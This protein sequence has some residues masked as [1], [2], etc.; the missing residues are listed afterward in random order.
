[1]RDLAALTEQIRVVRDAEK[2]FMSLWRIEQ[3]LVGPDV[4][5]RLADD[6]A[7]VAALADEV[8]A[9]T[10][11]AQDGGYAPPHNWSMN[12]EGDRTAA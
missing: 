2:R 11:A 3:V 1:M 4:L 10:D 7:E 6:L 9:L 12:G 8:L 5:D